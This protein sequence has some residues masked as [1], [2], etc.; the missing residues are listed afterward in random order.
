MANSFNLKTFLN[1]YESYNKQAFT[2][3][4]V[5]KEAMEAREIHEA[6]EAI[7]QA[8]FGALTI[9]E[10]LLQL[11]YGE[12]V[13]ELLKKNTIGMVTGI[14]NPFLEYLK[15]YEKIFDGS[16]RTEMQEHAKQMF[17]SKQALQ[18]DIQER[19]NDVKFVMD[20]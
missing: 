20:M 10:R 16:A 19:A 15:K 3:A 8:P 14:V 2:A 5:G 13:E 4:E 18:K 17:F 7:K 6:E 1:E 9:K 12:H 11:G